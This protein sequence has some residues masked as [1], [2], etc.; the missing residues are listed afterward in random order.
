MDKLK[1]KI[2]IVDDYADNRLVL[3]GMLKRL[4]YDTV[5]ANNGKVALE[6]IQTQ[7]FDM[8]MM[9]LEMPVMNGFETTQIIRRQYTP[10]ALPIWAITSHDIENFKDKYQKYKFNGYIGKPFTIDR[11]RSI[12]NY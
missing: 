11:I 4:G 12:L 6:K 3:M 10:E 1:K 2:L 8:I 9:D 7:K 5:Q